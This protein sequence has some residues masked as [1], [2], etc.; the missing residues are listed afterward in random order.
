MLKR[1][2]PKL[3]YFFILG[4]I[5]FIFFD[6]KIYPDSEGYIYYHSMRTIGYPIIIQ[7]LLKNLDL[8]VLFQIILSITAC[9]FFTQQIRKIYN[10]NNVANLFF[11]TVLILVSLKISLNILTGSVTF[12]LYLISVS[13]CMKSISEQKKRYLFLSSLILF[14]GV[15][16][17][18]QVIFFT[19]SLVIFISYFY[20]LTKK[21]II[22]LTIPIIF[23]IF[24]LPPK[25]N[26]FYNYKFNDVKVSTT[27]TWNQM[28]II[29]LFIS[30]E[31]M[32]KFLKNENEK[33]FQ[34][35][36]E[37][38]TSKG[39]RKDRAIQDGRNWLYVLETNS[40]EIK[41][42]VNIS[43]DKLFFYENMTNKERI[44]KEFF[45][46]VV[47]SHLIYNP[48]NFFNSYF[49][50]FSTA[51]FNKY[52]LG[53]FTF[54]SFLIF[55]YLLIFRNIKILIVF[56][57]IISHYSNIFLIN[58]GAPLLTRFK[59]YTEIILIVFLLAMIINFF[60]SKKNQNK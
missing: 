13:L 45:F 52:Y 24:Y 46:S 8:V 17:R 57:F 21:K 53:V 49:E 25:I 23:S 12:S 55:L 39:F 6:P 22:F 20:Y 43:I 4:S 30:T 28:M 35:S 26:K 56:S 37:C 7:I 50:K 48:F 38:V 32:K 27:D 11:S 15:L 1:I 51:F 5:T 36:I 47:K 19:S 10:L 3:I 58:L 9:F 18:P 42:C 34:E 31:E 14:L 33:I 60:N 16:I 59:F 29:P 2:S 44:S 40:F 54:F 41:N